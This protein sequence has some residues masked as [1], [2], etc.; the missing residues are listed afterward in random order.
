MIY[1]QRTEGHNGFGGGGF[2][3]KGFG[4]H[5]RTDSNATQTV[6]NSDKTE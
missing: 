4:G 6:Q 5:D 1:S 3:H 2:D